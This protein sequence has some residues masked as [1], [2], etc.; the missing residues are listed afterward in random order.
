MKTAEPGFGIYVH[1]PFCAAKCP[2]CDFNSHVRHG[3]IDEERFRAAYLRELET[4]AARVSGRTVSSIFFGGGTPSLMEPAT[5][6]AILDAIAGYWSLDE[7]VEV[8]LEANPGSTEA[9]RFAGYKSAGVNRLSLGVQA[10]DDESLGF[11]GRIHSADEARKAI[12]IARDIFPR[13]SF[14][15]IYARPEQAPDAW[16]A[17][18]TA[19]IDLAADHLSLY[20]LTIEA[21]TP[22]QRLRDAGK[23]V[24]PA[25]APAAELYQVTQ[26][27]CEGAGMPAYE[28]SNH[29]V[30]GAECRH[31][32][33][34]WR[35]GEYVGIG[36]GAHGRL[37]QE[38]GRHA[39]ATERNPEAWLG[40]VEKHGSGLVTDDLLIPEEIGDEFLVMG[41][42]LVEGVDI[43]R[44]EALSGRGLDERRLANL[45]E[46]GLIEDLGGD[47]LR[48]TPAGMLVLDAVVADL[49]S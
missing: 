1:W 35:Y 45:V 42:R 46:L 16:R 2:Y 4:M 47:R 48:T 24:V 3:G 7:N 44:Y 31:N 23:L 13:L 5:V 43:A 40:L 29:A 21:D 36:A 8:T 18:L 27:I 39:T 49:A 15:L 30:P 6:G 34:Y 17:E 37:A 32:L 41:L 10:L 12:G 28:I 25:E 9:T 22:F 19:A 33:L 26:E 14:D 38:H 11:L 20:Q